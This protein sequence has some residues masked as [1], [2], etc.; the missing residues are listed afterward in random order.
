MS[1]SALVGVDWGTTHLRVHRIDGEGRSL[2]RR[3]SALGIAHVR[4]RAFAAALEPLIADWCEEQPD[5]PIVLCGMVGSRHGWWEVPYAHCP[6]SMHEGACLHRIGLGERAAW[7]V[8]GLATVDARGRYDVMRGEETQILGA[9]DDTSAALIVT[10]GTHSK[11]ASVRDGRIE[12]FRTYLT[13]ELYGVLQQHSTLG[14][15]DNSESDGSQAETCFFEGLQEAQTE[16]DVLHALFS[17]RTRSLFEDFEPAAQ[18]AYLSGLLIGTEVLN[19]L[20]HCAA[21][22]VQ[23]VVSASLRKWYELAFTT[24]GV[25]DLHCLDADV[26]VARGLWRL[27]H[28]V[29]G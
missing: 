6:M 11:W 15:S 7:I 9:I 14:W 24:F 27:A 13:G 25:R 20:S 17:V 5:I 4:E 3:D 16:T 23:L 22:P 8:G 19:G 18:S 28:L 29:P 1:S 10:P 2:E 12:T 26:A 21:D